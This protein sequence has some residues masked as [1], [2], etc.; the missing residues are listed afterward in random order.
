M[1]HL[2]R[3][4]FITHLGA[5]AVAGGTLPLIARARSG[6]TSAS[7]AERVASRSTAAANADLRFGC[8]AITWGDSIDQAIADIA[9]AGYRG[10]QLRSNVLPVWG[11]RPEALKEKL[12]A[13]GLSFVA[14]S[15]GNVSIDPAAR[16]K[17]V[18]LHT[19]HAQFV[20]ACGGHYLQVT[21]ERPKG[22]TVTGEDYKTLGKLLTDIGKRTG[23]LGIP[24]GYHNHMGSLGE[25]PDEVDQI[26]SA[27]DPSAVKLELDVAHY[28]MGGGDPV[29]AIRTYAGRH[30]FLHIKDLQTP[31][32]G[33]AGE[34]KRSYRFVELGRGVVNLKGCFRALGDIAFR[35]WC[36][37]ELDEVPDHARTPKE[38]ALISK[39]F[40]EDE[41]RVKI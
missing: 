35:G 27:A 28:H 20:K 16:E 40:L 8:A 7:N 19:Q 37:V 36:I 2:T 29:K 25:R 24:L 9:A 38:S 4:A 18:D 14:L 17:Q 41:V 3:R 10:I 22:R 13:A 32:P 34:P 39:A 6:S 30:L 12:A 23:D 15:S 26:L 5:A 21:D 31:V 11:E 33:T 1:S